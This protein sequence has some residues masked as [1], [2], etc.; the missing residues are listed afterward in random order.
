MI[1][2]MATRCDE[3]LFKPTRIV[4]GRR[5]VEIV[6]G[7]HRDGKHF[8][9]HLGTIADHQDVWCRG[10]WD[11]QEDPAVVRFAEALGLVTYVTAEDVRNAPAHLRDTEPEDDDG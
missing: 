8:T 4:G 11:T 7:C 9:C 6:R 5:M 3:C 1:R 2:V 10:W